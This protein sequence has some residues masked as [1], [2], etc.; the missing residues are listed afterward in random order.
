MAITL[1]L[2]RP[3]LAAA[4]RSGW[5]HGYLRPEDTHRWTKKRVDGSN[6]VIYLQ[7]SPNNTH[8]EIVIDGQHL[9]LYDPTHLACALLLLALTTSTD[10]LNLITKKHI[11][12]A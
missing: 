9:T 2:I 5:Q 4:R 11:N 8:R 3:L 10:T 7:W 12:H 6:T 1:T